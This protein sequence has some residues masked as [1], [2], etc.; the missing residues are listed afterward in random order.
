MFPFYAK[1]FD[2]VN[3]RFQIAN[4]VKQY[5]I[6]QYSSN[7][8]KQS[9]KHARIKFD[10]RVGGVTSFVGFPSSMSVDDAL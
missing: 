5:L 10:I 6:S 1:I 7:K 4:N 2:R 3:K 9:N 8:V